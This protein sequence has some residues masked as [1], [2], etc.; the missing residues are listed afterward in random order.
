MN[1]TLNTYTQWYWKCDLHNLLHFLSLRID[2]HAQY[3]IRVYAEVIAELVKAW[4]PHA[5]EA[6]SDYRLGAVTLSA[7][8]IGTLRE[9]LE[10]YGNA[11]DALDEMAEG[12]LPK[13]E[14]AEFRAKL[15]R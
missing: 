5:W 10:L 2:S 9:M 14:L 6:F 4:V 12:R 11:A 13:R 7:A 1:L 15:R 3:E 8:E